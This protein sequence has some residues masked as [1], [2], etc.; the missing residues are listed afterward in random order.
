MHINS[1]RNT[2]EQAIDEPNLLQ[3]YVRRRAH[4]DKFKKLL[5]DTDKR[6]HKRTNP[7]TSES[8]PQGHGR[9]T[10]APGH[11]RATAAPNHGQA[12]QQTY[13]STLHE[14]TNSQAQIIE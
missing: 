13:L 7:R 8:L 12:I 10:I 5:H 11:K 1:K 9:A 14:Q 2:S 4:A 6:V 3:K